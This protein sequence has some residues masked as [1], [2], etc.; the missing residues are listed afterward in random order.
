MH[1]VRRGSVDRQVRSPARGRPTAGERRITQG[2]DDRGVEFCDHVLGRALRH[3]NP[4]PDR[5]VKARQ[6]RLINGRNVG[7]RRKPRCSGHGISLDPAAAD[8]RKRVRHLIEVEVDL[9]RNEVLQSWARTAI[10]HEGK[11]RS[12]LALEV[13]PADVRRAARSHCSPRST[14]P[15][16]PSPRQSVPSGSLPAQFGARR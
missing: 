12:R 1:R 16:F 14:S 2:I 6:S 10:G 15:G 5:N 11:S 13:K 9:S 3:P 8:V 7:R 4:V